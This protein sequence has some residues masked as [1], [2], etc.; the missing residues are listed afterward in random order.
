MKQRVVAGVLVVTVVVAA[1]GGSSKKSAT[2]IT[3]KPGA[4]TNAPT[5]TTAEVLGAST[6]NT[7]LPSVTAPPPTTAAPKK[8]LPD[9]RAKSV[10]AARADLTKVGVLR[11]IE[12]P[13]EKYG[14]PG[15]VLDQRPSSGEPV[16]E[17]V[18]LSVSAALPA[19]P[20]EKGKTFVEAKTWFEHRDVK[21]E[22]ENQLSDSQLEDTLLATVPAAGEKIPKTVKLVVAK[23]PT[24]LALTGATVVAG[25]CTYDSAGNA[26]DSNTWSTK[27]ASID[28]KP[29]PA[30]LAAVFGYGD[31]RAEAYCRYEYDLGRKWESFATDFGVSDS[32]ASG[33]SAH[34]EVYVREGAD[35]EKA[36]EQDIVLGVPT[37]N[38]RVDVKNKLR[39]IVTVRTLSRGAATFVMGN[40]R[41]IGPTSGSAPAATSAPS[42]TT[43]LK[44]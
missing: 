42:T 6:T 13:V 18:T 23:K 44:K 2:P 1:C 40:P 37:Y 17:T 29:Y 24:T 7:T 41:L 43:T 30:A 3:A 25:G 32:T 26:T 21:I 35:Y 12:D 39:M 31:T 22:V 20:D 9:V 16:E 38:V 19:M 11:V 8:V 14:D 36:F 27:E 15:F 28:G 34:V 33:H 10:A 4:S 5:T